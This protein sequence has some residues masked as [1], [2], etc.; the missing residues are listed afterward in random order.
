[1]L[2][3][4]L[5]TASEHYGAFLGGYWCPCVPQ[6]I[7]DE[8]NLRHQMQLEGFYDF[9]TDTYDEKGYAAAHYG[10]HDRKYLG[11]NA[12]GVVMPTVVPHD[13]KYLGLN[14]VGLS[15]TVR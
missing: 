1:M 2:L 7:I 15:R 12:V 13:R 4:D 14:A 8:Y 6:W 9:R 3:P 11:L 10:K 5:H